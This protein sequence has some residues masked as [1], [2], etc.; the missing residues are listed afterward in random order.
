MQPIDGN[1]WTA[2]LAQLMDDLGTWAP[3]LLTALVVLVAGFALAWLLRALCSIVFKRLDLDER[4][5]NLWLFQIWSRSL[6]GRSPS[7]SMASFIF[8]LV[9][10]VVILLAIRLLGPEGGQAILSSL[11]GVIPR[12]LSFMLILFLGFLLAMFFSVL[13]QLALVGS[14]A[15]HPSFWG[16][17][18]AWGTFGLTV[19]FSLEPLGLAGQF[20]TTLAL[21]VLGAMG[22]AAAIALGLGCKDLA[23]EFVIELLKGNDDDR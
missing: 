20:L 3:S 15:Q 1:I 10:F 5:G 11:L 4:L 7:Q 6:H 19:M 21:M 9:I 17:V 2:P 14:G 13:A 23:R 12:V 16:K 18:I 22:L 8:Y